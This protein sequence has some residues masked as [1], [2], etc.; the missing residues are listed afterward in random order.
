MVLFCIL[1]LCAAEHKID[2]AVHDLSSRSV[3]QETIV[4]VSDRL[5]AMLIETGL[6]RV[7]ER[8]SMNLIL[9]EQGF[10]QTGVCDESSCFVEAGQLLGVDRMIAGSIARMGTRYTISLRMFDVASGEILFTVNEDFSG[11]IEE[12]LDETLLNLSYALGTKVQEKQESLN[13]YSATLPENDEGSRAFSNAF[14]TRMSKSKEAGMDKKRRVRQLLLGVGALIAGG[15]G[16]HFNSLSKESLAEYHE[17]E[18]YDQEV[19]QRKW[20]RYETRTTVR[21]IFYGASGVLFASTLISFK[22]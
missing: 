6:F 21:N 5:R 11:A 15:Y 1:P 20:E 3:T 19:H 9:E 14:L 7:L 18:S 2:I 10:Q 17:T 8:N 16:L 22:F 4:I 13:L 12:Q